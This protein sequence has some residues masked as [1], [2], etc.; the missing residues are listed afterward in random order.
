M[1]DQWSPSPGEAA[2]MRSRMRKVIADRYG[3]WSPASL[4][5]LAASARVAYTTLARFVAYKE[6][7]RR[8]QSLRPAVL[9]AVALALDIRPEWLLDG[10]GDQQLGFW[11]ILVSE[12]AESEISSPI[13][14]VLTALRGLEHLTPETVLRACRAAVAAML[15][16]SSSQGE[17]MPAEAYR[18]LMRLD[19]LQRTQHVRRAG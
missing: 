6:P 1:P 5:D 14:Q 3:D 19:A 11:P 18:C 17:V 12:E 16:T 2:G 9:R 15:D 4:R 13:D 7:E 10:Q 8:T